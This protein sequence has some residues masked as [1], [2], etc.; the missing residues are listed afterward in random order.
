MLFLG[1]VLTKRAFLS[2]M[3]HVRLQIVK[4]MEL[5]DKNRTVCN[6]CLF[7][8]IACIILYFFFTKMFEAIIILI[9]KRSL[10]PLFRNPDLERALL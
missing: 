6:H 4:F 10:H 1:Q 2:R 5:E 3:K 9:L 7:P 8:Y